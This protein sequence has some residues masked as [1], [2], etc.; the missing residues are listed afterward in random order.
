MALS[1]AAFKT[2][3]EEQ[4]KPQRIESGIHMVFASSQNHMKVMISHIFIYIHTY[5]LFNLIIFFN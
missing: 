5:I 4:K 1:S 2:V 3:T